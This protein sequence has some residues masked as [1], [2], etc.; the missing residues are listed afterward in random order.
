MQKII[1][2]F[3]IMVITSTAVFADDFH[4]LYVNR[5]ANSAKSYRFEELNRIPVKIKI[6]NDVTTKKNL[7]EGQKLVFLTTESV[8][9]THKKVLSEGSRVFGTVETISQNEMMGVPSNLII[10][11][12]KIEYM[13]TIKLEGQIVKQGANRALWVRPLAP[14]FFA[15]RGGHAKVKNDETYILYYT[16]PEL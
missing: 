12:F 5:F 13:P 4:R 16:P 3:L 14:I 6:M 10:G 1:Y 2:T 11:N 15:V 9:L 7:V 8:V